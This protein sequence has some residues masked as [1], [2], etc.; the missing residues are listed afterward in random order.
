MNEPAAKPPP[1]TAEDVKR[2]LRERYPL[3]DGWITMAEVTPPKTQRR[4]DLVAI[5]GWQSRGHEVLGFEV[6]VSRSDWLAELKDPAKADPLVRLCSRWWIAAPPNVVWAEELPPAWGLLVIH[7]EQIRAAK[8]APQ[9]NPDPWTDAVW[10]CMMLRQA[11]RES[12]TADELELARQEGARMQ[13]ERSKENAEREQERAA[14]R[15]RGLRELIEKAGQATGVHLSKWT[16]FPALGEAMQLIRGAGRAMTIDRLER[17]ART[18]R[19]TAVRMRLAARSIRGDG[20]S[21]VVA[22]PT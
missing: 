13:F 5:M 3:Q 8:Q 17:D 4:F 12:R 14:E 18:L 19:E 21:G 16:D 1:L 6:K 11:T 10:R 22:A 9:L 2:R 20:V 7:P 15:E